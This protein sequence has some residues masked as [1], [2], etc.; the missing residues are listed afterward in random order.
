[1]KTS[2]TSRLSNVMTGSTQRRRDMRQAGRLIATLVGVA[3]WTV[4]AT[5]VAQAQRL[6]DPTFI[7]A[8]AATP[9]PVTETSNWTYAAIAV[10]AA[11][12]AVAVVGLVASLRHSR[13]TRQSPMLHA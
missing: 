5:T 2:I 9:T 3:F 1:M 10:L 6:H 12:M 4:V 13:S 8:P 11:L 7:Q